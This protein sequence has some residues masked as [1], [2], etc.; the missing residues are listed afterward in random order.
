MSGVVE[1]IYVAPR[2]RQ[3]PDAVERAVAVAGRGLEG[4][5]YHDG[6][7]SFSHW[8]G[9]RD[10]TLIGAEAFEGID[11]DPAEAR[12]NVV[13]RGLD[14]APLVGRRFRVGEVECEA[15]ELNPP[16]KHL[17]RL[18]RPGVMRALAGRGGIRAAILTDGEIAVGD[19]VVLVR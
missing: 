12:R 10:L 4:D 2:K 1:A 7:G 15:V 5:R 19:A 11:L 14:L 3:L 9:R 6:A 18:T 8:P 16:C 17:E 13:V